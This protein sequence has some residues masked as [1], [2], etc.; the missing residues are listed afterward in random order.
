MTGI[1]YTWNS[2]ALTGVLLAL[3]LVSGEIGYRIGRR[4]GRR[5]DRGTK[6]QTNAIQAAMLGLLALLLGFTFTMSLQ[7]FDSRSQAL[8]DETNA[9][10]TTYL[11]A[12]LL[13]EV[14]RKATQDALKQYVGLRLRESRLALTD[15]TLRDLLLAES[16]LLSGELWAQAMTAAAADPRP[17]TSGLFI[18][19]LNE[20]I[21]AGARR[22]A[23]LR[24]HVPEIVLLLLFAVLIIA[25]AVVGYAG[26]LE[27][28]RPTVAT[29]AMTVLIVMVVFII[30]DLDRPR[31]GLIQINQDSLVTLSEGLGISPVG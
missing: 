30:I 6:S 28:G 17:V 19:S 9:I 20:M 29:L 13:P 21:D 31:R 22:E 25:E 5:V 15:S 23:A 10:G 7:R 16:E 26:G 24:K 11:R 4:G 27:G 2:L 3:A 12:E 14:Q 1:L 8:V 18:Q